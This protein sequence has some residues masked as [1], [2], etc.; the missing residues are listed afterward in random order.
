M[1]DNRILVWLSFAVF[2]CVVAIVWLSTSAARPSPDS[3]AQTGF[4]NAPAGP[5]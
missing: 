2:V 4:S 5:K 3:R 1:S